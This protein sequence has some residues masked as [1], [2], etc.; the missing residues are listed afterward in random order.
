VNGCIDEYGSGD[1]L[2]FS[3]IYSHFFLRFVVFQDVAQ[4]LNGQFVRSRSEG[5]GFEP[6]SGTLLCVL[7]QDT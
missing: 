3:L 6:W 2:L 4:W 5:S 1:S 7:R